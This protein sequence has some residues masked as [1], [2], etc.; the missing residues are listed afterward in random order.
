MISRTSVMPYRGKEKMPRNRQGARSFD[1]LEGSVRKDGNRVR[2]NVQLIN[3]VNDEHIWSEVYDVISRTFRDPDG[4]GAEMPRSAGETFANEKAL[5][6][7][8]PTKRRGLSR[9]CASAHPAR[10]LETSTSC[11][12]AEQLYERRCSSTRFAL[13]AAQLPGWKLDLPFL[14]PGA[15]ASRERPVLWP[16]AIACN[17]RLRGN[18]ARGSVYYGDRYRD[19]LKEFAIA[20]GGLPKD[21]TSISPLGDPASAGQM[22]ESTAKPQGKRQP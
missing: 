19:A 1:L 17:P 7:R 3:A 2:V 12:N 10:Q 20:Q 13:A 14:R 21:A 22:E 15:V 18:L 11:C 6:D 5:M 16:N 9:F 4:P 8:K